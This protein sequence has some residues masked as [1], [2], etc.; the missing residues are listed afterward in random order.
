MPAHVSE[1]IAPAVL[2][3]VLIT[4]SDSPARPRVRGDIEPEPLEHAHHRILV[5][6]ADAVEPHVGAVV[7]AI[8]VEPEMPPRLPGR[9]RELRAIPIGIAPRIPFV[10]QI[11]EPGE[12]MFAVEFV[13]RIGDPIALQPEA[14]SG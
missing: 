10:R 4:S 9:Q 3:D 11:A 5:G 13:G 8:E 12:V 1:Q 7:D 6:D 2:A 14:G